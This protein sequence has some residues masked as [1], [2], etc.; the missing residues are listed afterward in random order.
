M[1]YCFHLRWIH[2]LAGLFCQDWAQEKHQYSSV[3][4]RK[5]TVKLPGD[6]SWHH[7]V[8]TGSSTAVTRDPAQQRARHEKGTSNA[9]TWDP[10]QQWA[11]H[12]KGTGRSHQATWSC[13]MFLGSS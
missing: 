12:G 7:W 3:V 8:E 2:V 5:K 11:R 1:T 9:V 13:R 6:E 4:L 10:A